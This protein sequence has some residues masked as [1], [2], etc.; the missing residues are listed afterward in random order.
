MLSAK[1]RGDIEGFRDPDGYSPKWRVQAAS[2][3]RDVEKM[4]DLIVSGRPQ[5]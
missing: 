5:R 3:A 4:A 1:V 2:K